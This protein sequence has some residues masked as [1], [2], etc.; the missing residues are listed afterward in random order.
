MSFLR[1]LPS[2]RPVTESLGVMTAQADDFKQTY[3]IEQQW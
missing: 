2:C 3:S 1:H